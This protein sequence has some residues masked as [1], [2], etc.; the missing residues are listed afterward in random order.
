MLLN[1]N[2]S[3]DLTVE[4]RSSLRLE[5]Y[6]NGTQLR[7]PRKRFVIVKRWDLTEWLYGLK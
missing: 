2:R 4:I 5:E 1:L 3:F 6:G 7:F